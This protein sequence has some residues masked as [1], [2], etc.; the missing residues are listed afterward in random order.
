MNNKHYRSD[1]EYT[2]TNVEAT[3]LWLIV[4]IGGSIF[5][6]RIWIWIVATIIW[7]NH[8]TRHLEVRGDRNE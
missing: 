3:I 5:T 2:L 1:T 6:D 8:I 4:M 7:L